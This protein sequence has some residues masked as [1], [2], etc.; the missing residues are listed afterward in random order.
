M[1]C[2]CDQRRF[3]PKLDI[4]AGL[5]QVPRQ[6]AIF[7]EWRQSMLSTLARFTALSR[8][9]G[10]SKDDLGIML[11]EMWAYVCDIISFY[12]EVIAHE[13]YLRTARLRPSLRKLVALLGYIPRPAVSAKV[14]LAAFADGRRPVI[15]PV[16]TAFRSGAFG[17]NPPQVFELDHPVEI[18]P[19][20]NQWTLKPIRP[21]TIGDPPY[22]APTKINAF[23]CLP[24][25]VMVKQDDLLFV[26]GSASPL[27][28][29]VAAIG[30]QTG[31]DGGLYTQIK[32][33]QPVEFPPETEIGD[34]EILTP[35]ANGGLWKAGVVS[36]SED[37]SAIEGRKI[38]LD[39]IYRQIL[40][41]SYILLKRGDDILWFQVTQVAEQM[42]T[43]LGKQTSELQ[44]SEGTQTGKVISPAVTVPV[45]KLTLSDPLNWNSDDAPNI[46]IY[47][48]LV[49]AGQLARDL[50][51]TLCKGDALSIE[52]PVEDPGVA[53]AR[54]LLE[55]KNGVGLTATGLIDFMIGTFSVDSSVI[56]ENPL[57]VPVSLYGNVINGTR[58]ETVDS[59]ILGIGDSSQA[60]QSFKLKKKPLAYV[61]SPTS[62]ND[63]GVA[64]TLRVYVDGVEWHEVPTFFGVKE[65]AQ[66]YVVRQ[67]D[68]EETYITFGGGARLP[69]GSQVVANYKFGSG[70]AC[71]PAG[72]V[73]QLAKPVTG[74][75]SIRNPVSSFGGDD[76]ESGGQLAYFAPRSALLLGRV[77]SIQDMEAAGA[78]VGGVRSVSA[79]WRWNRRRQQPVVQIYYIGDQGLSDIITQKLHCLSDP[80]TPVEVTR[81]APLIRRLFLQIEIDGHYIET[82]VIKAVRAALM[83]KLSG[84]LAPERVGIGKP[85]FRS[86]IFEKA[87]SVPGTLAVHGM[88]LDS[89]SFP[90]YGVTPGEGNYFD[91]E[92]GSLYLNRISNE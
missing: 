82:D 72:S 78:T 51:R 70:A 67:D 89:I 50:G 3:F 73:R 13:S 66:V 61:N 49:R 12:D 19:Q 32:L 5:N 6:Y 86:R 42:R 79:E 21:T 57:T 20:L 90:D 15:L 54:F 43:I 80:A 38:V 62:A 2:P 45:T 53:P 75:K 85:L 9:R 8:W 87:L 28:R 36:E 74:L 41:G 4:P 76:R 92:N 91:F 83:D 33:D 17:S 37:S 46:T 24:G 52:T 30:A 29:K 55:D 40:Q 63:Q 58:G 69:T 26:V 65:N 71:P 23:Q 22:E 64:S 60:T 88:T 81:A 39:G 7:P 48:R 25:T 14:V 35:T 18:L 59:D 44:D 34:I 1:S 56:W 68:E 16:G 47:Y 10:R 77:V 31:L 11:L 84:L 27:V